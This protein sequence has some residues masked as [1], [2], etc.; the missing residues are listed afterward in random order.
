MKKQAWAGIGLF[1]YVWLMVGFATGTLTLLGPARWVTSGLRRIGWGGQENGVMILV[2]LA[3]VVA[4]F[5][6]ARALTAL[7]RKAR[8]RQVRFGVPGIATL[9]AGLALWGWMNPAVYATVAGGVAGTS[10]NTGGAEFVFGGY[11]DR[12]RL[13]ELKAQ[14]YAGVISLQHPAVL[15]FEPPAIQAEEVAARELGIQ[16]VSAP[17][18]PWVSSNEAS[19][20]KIRLIAVGGKGRYYVH[21]GLGRDRTNVVKRMLERTGAAMVAGAPANAE[22][23]TFQMRWNEGRRFMERGGFRT[24]EKDVWLIPYP[25]HHELYGNMLAGQIKHVFVLLDPEDG[26]QAEWI[27]HLQK[28]LGDHG[29]E[30]TFEPL[31]IGSSAWTADMVASAKTLPR[32]L[33]IVLPHTPPHPYGGPA[34]ELVR[35]WTGSPWEF[36][37]KW[38]L[39]PVVPAPKSASVAAR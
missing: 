16:F 3:F 26:Q 10:V 17:M 25:N 31:R 6:I 29:I 5:L 23:R 9:A 15:P 7:I 39:V 2:I 38:D 18:L 27:R 21:C 32:P 36:K 12:A 24:L 11:P 1:L 33:A 8:T 30:A 4:S 22:A 34:Q 19:L 13:Q 28:Q 37:E 20:E 14:G 35:E